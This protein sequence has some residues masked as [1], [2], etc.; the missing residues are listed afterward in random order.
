M[1]ILQ[2]MCIRDS[3]LGGRWG[4]KVAQGHAMNKIFTSK[5]EVMKIIE[6]AILLFREQGKTCLLYTSGKMCNGL[7][8]T[9][10]C[11]KSVFHQ[12]L[13]VS[14]YGNTGNLNVFRCF[15]KNFF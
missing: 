4:K 10:I 3:Y 8:N 2:K 15:F 6:K 12:I 5:E 11:V 14:R 1:L 9:K 13:S 7:N